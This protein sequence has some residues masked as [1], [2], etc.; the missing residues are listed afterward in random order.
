M[1][2]DLNPQS[3]LQSDILNMPVQKAIFHLAWPTI[4]SGILENLTTTVDMIMVGTLGAPA[5]AAVGFC[6]MINWTLSSL[7]MGLSIAITA[8]V[9]RSYG[10]GQKKDAEFAVAQAMILAL[11]LAAGIALIIFF[12]APW[13]LRFLGVQNDVYELAVPYLKIISFS[14]L[15]FAVLITLG[16]ALRGAGDTR[17]P[18]YIGFISNICNVALNYV[19]IFGKMG[20]PALGVTGAAIGSMISL[21]VATLLLVILCH[22][23][24]LTLQLSFMHFR[25]DSGRMRALIRMAIP[26]SIEQ[27]VVQL[28]L[29]VY[30]RF[31][32]G[33][34]T[35]ALSGYQVGSQ[36]LSLSFIPNGAFSIAAST[37]VGQNLG[38]GRKSE[39]K[40]AAWICLGLGT[41]SMST[42]AAITLFNAEFL[43]SVFVK[44]PDVIH[45]G[46]NFIAIVAFSQPAMAVY[47]ILAGA[48]R[49][50]GDTRSPL[51]V[52]LICMYGIRIPGAFLVSLFMDMGIELTFGLLIL[53]YIAR[54]VGILYFFRKGKWME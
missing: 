13:I 28:G 17:T 1:S 46:A 29:L 22:T 42:V 54:A 15:F 19:L 12:G 8:M 39:A 10:G 37:L 9:A 32:V 40:R 34:G 16:G 18:L 3:D 47:F 38:A 25:W 2:E 36:V 7:M 43:A 24:W 5:I 31:I 52:T 50:A 48:L 53:D 11:I 51:Y 33:F 41:L 14:G 26:A 45:L 21:L 4:F 23:G 44:E 20:F 30:A 6:G 27:F 35:A 49:G